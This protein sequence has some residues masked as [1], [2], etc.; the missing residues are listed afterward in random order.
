MTNRENQQ[1]LDRLALQYLAAVETE[2]FDTI[3]AL[4]RQA[5]DDADLDA[6]L[7]GLNA[8]LEAEQ[9]GATQILAVTVIGVGEPLRLRQATQ[10]QAGRDHAAEHDDSNAD[11][12]D[13]A[14]DPE[15]RLIK[16]AS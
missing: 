2:D 11:R 10:E 14:R 9:D 15:N 5:A 13:R 8:E 1:R 3:D 16:Q 12:F 4:W 7:H 6:M